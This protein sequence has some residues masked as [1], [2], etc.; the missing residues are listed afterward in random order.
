MLLRSPVAPEPKDLVV[1]V[2]FLGLRLLTD[3]LFDRIVPGG[4]V[5]N[6]SSTAGR[7]WERR[8]EYV[9]ALVRSEDFDAG[10]EWLA[11]NEGRWARDPYT[12]SKQC[13]TF[14]TKLAAER[15]AQGSVRV[16]SVSPGS[17]DTQLTPAFRAQLGEDFA[18][19]RLAVIDRAATPAEMAEPVVWFAIG[20]SNWVNGADLIV[21][22]GLESGFQA[23]WV[24]IAD[25]PGR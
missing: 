24:D 23:G 21:D 25:A 18:D 4:S 14:W 1:K 9:E 8:R 12:F 6:V 11:A 2:N 5:V 13:V 20:T 3:G 10:V 22:R 7:S 15:G 17:V 16:N 19:W